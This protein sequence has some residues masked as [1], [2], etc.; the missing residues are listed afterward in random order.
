ME[1][2]EGGK[3]RGEGKGGDG[4]KWKRM[5]EEKRG[6]RKK[7]RYPLKQLQFENVGATKYFLVL[8]AVSSPARL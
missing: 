3:E 4:A 5:G 6:K 2:R 1:G 7:G 8:S